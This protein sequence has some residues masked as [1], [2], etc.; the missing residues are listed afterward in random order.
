MDTPRL[1][2]GDEIK[3][4]ISRVVPPQIAVKELRDHAHDQIKTMFAYQLSRVKLRPSKIDKLGDFIANKTAR[5]SFQPGY[6]VGFNVAES[7]GQPATQLVLNAFHSAGQAGQ[8]E[9]GRF[10][11]LIKPRDPKK[12]GPEFSMKIHM[13]NKDFTYEDLYMEAHKFVTVSIYDLLDKDQVLREEYPFEDTNIYTPDF[14]EVNIYQD[15]GCGIRL[16]FNREK[17]FLYKIP[18]EAIGLELEKLA[19]GKLFTVFVGPQIEGIID[20]YPNPDLL[21]NNEKDL[22]ENCLIFENGFLKSRMQSTRLG[23]YPNVSS[24]SIVKAKVVDLIQDVT[25][26]YEG[27]D[28]SETLVQVWIDWVFAKKEGI[29]AEKL[30]NLLET[31]GYPVVD[32]DMDGNY[33]IVRSE[34][35]DIQK[36]IIKRLREEDAKLIV[37]YSE[38]RVLNSTKLYIDGF[39][40]YIQTVGSNLADVRNHPDVDE[41]NT[42]SDSVIEI[43]QT[44]GIEVAR[45]YIEKEIY[46]LFEKNDQYIA[47]RNIGIMVDWMTSSGR[48]IAVNPKNIPKAEN[49]IIRAMCFENPKDNIVK[50]AVISTEEPLSS[51]TSRVLFGVEQTLGT[52]AFDLRESPEITR[53]YESFQGETSTPGS[54]RLTSK[55]LSDR[56]EP[57]G[58]KLPSPD[59][60]LFDES[61]LSQGSD[62]DFQ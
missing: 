22:R 3:Q 16:R 25:P 9:F 48:L 30:K 5:A 7:I 19:E 4:I 33:Y 13:K 12:Y 38:T 46:D 60:D 17:L 32:T 57:V 47:P 44:M 27:D 6:P 54:Y 49:S 43:Y 28:Q 11:N 23:R 2:T 56:V 42:I 61:D 37:E 36:D 29:P 50:G 14:K 55:V 59:S 52:G 18:I 45:A 58:S 40:N 53:L 8:S 41:F 15:R 24:V 20:I 21:Q 26:H 51:F 10:K 31:A 62:F 39:Y 34:T 1:L 35:L